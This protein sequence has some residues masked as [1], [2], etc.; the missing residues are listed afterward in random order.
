MSAASCTR[1]TGSATYTGA[2]P[3]S[4]PCTV[5]GVELR[6]RH[7]TASATLEADFDAD[8]DNDCHDGNDE[9][10]SPSAA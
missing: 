5:G 7:F 4:T 2:Q 1:L 8:S 6:G 9:T 3:A 10:A